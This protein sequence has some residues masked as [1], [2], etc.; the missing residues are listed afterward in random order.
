[1]QIDSPLQVEVAEERLAAAV[2]YRR[3]RTWE[4]G[5]QAP[6]DLVGRVHRRRVRVCALPRTVRQNSWAPVLRGELSPRAPH[7]SRLVGTVGWFRSTRVLTASMLAV[8][9]VLVLAGVVATL[10]ALTAG[11]GVGDRPWLVVFG[12][13]LGGWCVALSWVGGSRGWATESE[14][15]VRMREA[16]DAR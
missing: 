3:T 10:V 15:L 16:L 9:V 12:L 8:A 14:L 4:G 6:L 7:G 5:G 11:D 13:V 1:M 2:S